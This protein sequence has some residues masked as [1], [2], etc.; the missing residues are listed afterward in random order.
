[1]RTALTHSHTHSHA[2]TLTHIHT[3]SHTHSHTINVTAQSALSA[4]EAWE[5]L[6]FEHRAAVFLKAAD[7]LST[8]YRDEVLA[9]TMIGQGKTMIQAEIDAAAEAAD[10]YRFG[11][12]FANE[13]YGE[14]PRHHSKFVWNR[15]EHRGLEGFVA[16]IPPFNFTA[17][18]ANLGAT[19]AL[20]GNVVLWKP[21]DTAALSNY[22]V[23]KALREAGMPD[24]VVNFVPADGP[25]FGQ[26]I[27]SSPDLAAISFTGSTK[28]FNTLWKGVADNLDKYKTYPRLVGEC[29]GKNFHFVHNTAQLDN[30]V[31]G[32][33][34]SAFEYQG[35]KCSAC[36][37]LYVPESMWPEFRDKMVSCMNDIKVG[38]PDDFTSFM[39][40]V[41]DENSFKKITSYIDYAKESPEMEILAGGNADMSKGYF[42]E[43]TFVQTTNPKSK[44]MEE[45]IFGPVVTAYVYPDE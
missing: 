34:R 10:F 23:F 4:R 37:R 36:S 41:I 2:Y 12:K 29:G 22:V 27:L 44:L 33:I 7:L 40:A 19:P 24:G 31:Y 8:S 28:T 14:Q 13:I 38:E 15:V 18:G 42:V 16:G 30:A 26:H 39:T 35:Q 17:I 43:P 6:D 1:M 32:T 3:H 9:A 20:M 5:A 45:E 11:V 25:T 21:S